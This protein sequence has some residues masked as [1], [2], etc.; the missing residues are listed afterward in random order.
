MELWQ[1]VHQLSS[2]VDTLCLENP[3]SAISLP[4]EG[5]SRGEAWGC[6]RVEP[7]FLRRDLSPT[8][9]LA[10]A[11]QLLA[12]RGGLDK[13]RIKLSSN[14]TEKEYVVKNRETWRQKTGEK[15]EASSAMA[16]ARRACG[17]LFRNDTY[18]DKRRGQLA[19]V[20]K[21]HCR[22]KTAQQPHLHGENT[23]SSSGRGK[24]RRI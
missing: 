24:L 23:T 13:R 22:A 8:P 2:L 3:P 19:G 14:A 16:M 9:R 21:R 7:L 10:R 4:R 6:N 12:S 20:P 17:V 1:A 18:R 11:L 5:E 15:M